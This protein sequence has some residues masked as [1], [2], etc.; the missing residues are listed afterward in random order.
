MSS[1]PES[2]FLFA[3][4][5]AV[6]PKPESQER[7]DYALGVFVEEFRTNALRNLDRV[8]HILTDLPEGYMDPATVQ[9]IHVILKNLAGQGRSYNFELISEI[10]DMICA[11]LSGRV[12]GSSKEMA[13]VEKAIEAMRLILKQDARG[14]G[15]LTERALV[16]CLKDAFAVD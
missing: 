7:L 3:A 4:D 11:F 12:E 1:L 15:G 9:S 13:L 16:A 14:E 8:D 5:E 6:S 10:G 2:E